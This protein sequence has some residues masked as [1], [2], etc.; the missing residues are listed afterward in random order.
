MRGP[1]R[2]AARMRGGRV[3]RA[4]FTAYL[5][6]TLLGLAYLVTVGLLRL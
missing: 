2:P 6:F 3:K 1:R 4:M 5:A